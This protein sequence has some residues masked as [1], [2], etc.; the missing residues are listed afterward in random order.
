MDENTRELTFSGNESINELFEKLSKLLVP[1]SMVHTEHGVFQ[2][3]YLNTN[4]FTVNG[5]SR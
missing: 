1:T 4:G 5:S 2:I 3:T